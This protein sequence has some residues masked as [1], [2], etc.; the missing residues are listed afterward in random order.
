[1]AKQF[2]YIS[3]Q[4]KVNMGAFVY[5]QQQAAAAVGKNGYSDNQ[6]EAKNTAVDTSSN[7]ESQGG[8]SLLSI[9]NQAQV[10]KRKGSYQNQTIDLRININKANPVPAQA[11]IPIMQHVRGKNVP[12]GLL[13][14]ATGGNQGT[15]K[16]IGNLSCY[17]SMG[18]GHVGGGG[19]QSH[20]GNFDIISQEEAQKFLGID[21][22]S[23]GGKYSLPKNK[24]IEDFS[25]LQGQ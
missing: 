11:G 16:S 19:N 13:R 7:A 24:S 2:S 18:N 20:N 1:M 6:T 17:R 22:H 23:S 12:N 21:S 4:P 15:Q 3:G 25:V 10:I 9:K 14:R 5:S 8:R